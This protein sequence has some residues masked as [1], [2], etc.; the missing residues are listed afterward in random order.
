VDFPLNHDLMFVYHDHIKDLSTEEDMT[1]VSQNSLPF[2]IEI[3]YF[4]EGIKKF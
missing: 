1:P 4:Q 3:A 2:S